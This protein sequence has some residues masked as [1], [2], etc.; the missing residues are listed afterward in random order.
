MPSTD[1]YQPYRSALLPVERVRELS[2]LRPAR[3]VLDTTLAWAGILGAWTVVALWPSV[4]T[5]LLAMPVIGTRYYALFIIGHD[6]MHRRLF[7]RAW[8]NDLFNDVFIF[9]PIGA[10][11][12][13]NCRNHLNHHK[14]LATGEDPDRHK[15]RSADK[16]DRLTL[17]AF[18]TGLRSLHASLRN[19]FVGAEDAERPAY[20][21]RDLAILALTQALLI[22]G[23]TWAIGFWAWPL[24]WVLPVFAFMFLADNLR[25]FAEHAHPEPDEQADL[26][27]LISFEA[28]LPE[29]V[30]LAP[31]NMN[32]H[33]VH[34]LWPSIP[35]YN[36]P[37]ADAEIR[38]AGESLGLE[39]R[40]SYGEHLR[41]YWRA[42]P[43]AGTSGRS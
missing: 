36:L 12:R 18:V 31:M 14:K 5:V 15:H 26:H 35:Y 13:I 4:W 19:V 23:L 21:P 43:L 42:L 1:P 22:G 6:G 9:A 28:S 30:L 40:A 16:R 37:L 27:R 8:L 33:A 10:I 11:T 25:S 20:Q 7:R 2:R 3:V 32:Y 41:N 24:L 38:E 39:W 34:H 17:L 29:R